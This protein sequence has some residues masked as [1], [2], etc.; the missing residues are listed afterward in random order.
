MSY[1][2]DVVIVGGC[3]HV[4]L[5]L[6]LVLADTGL[7]VIAY[8]TNH[9]TCLDVNSGKMP[10]LEFGMLHVWGRVYPSR[11]YAISTSDNSHTPASVYGMAP[12]VIVSVGTPV[13]E[14]GQPR[15]NKFLD[16]IREM[17]P[18]LSP[19]QH[20][21]VRSTV[22]PGTMR[23]VAEILG[24]EIGL[25]YC[26]ER[27]VEGQAIRELRTLPQIVS[28]G[29]DDDSN[30]ATRF[31]KNCLGVETVS[32]YYEEA[33]LAKLFLNSWRYVQFAAANEFYR[34]ATELGVDYSRVERAMKEGYARAQGLPGPGFAAGPCLL[35]DTMQ[36][37]GA[38]SRGF[39]L[40]QAARLANEGLPELLAKRID[41]HFAERTSWTSSDREDRIGILGMAFKADVDDLRDS[42]SFRLR[43]VLEFRGYEVLCSDEHAPGFLPR[44]EV[45]DRCGV[46]VVAVPH[47]GY[48]GLDLKD[49]RVVDLWGITQGGNKI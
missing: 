35:K 30:H 12:V 11:F 7:R 19:G 17:R 32:C 39:P 8:D 43:K 33:E 27:I 46:I 40:G 25:S 31:W 2:Y 42:L 21:M 10:F 48:R 36:L 13:D 5:P 6:G 22:F 41:R 34:I 23:R 9:S 47:E 24:S 1:D 28:V 45:I 20:V 38:D 14:Y 26:P 49:R 16:L 15:F 3:G 37:A 29:N 18:H 4:G 44:G